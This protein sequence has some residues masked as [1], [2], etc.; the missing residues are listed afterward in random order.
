MVSE[1][2]LNEKIQ[3]AEEMLK[4]HNERVEFFQR[5]LDD[6]RLEQAFA[7]GDLIKLRKLKENLGYGAKEVVTCRQ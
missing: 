7:E 3:I 2:E 1:R 5:A 4:I 6:A